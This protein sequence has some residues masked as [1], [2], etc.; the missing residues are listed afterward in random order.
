LQRHNP[1]RHQAVSALRCFLFIAFAY[2]W[3][4]GLSFPAILKFASAGC[5]LHQLPVKK[6]MLHDVYL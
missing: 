2:N 6:S 3:G 1:A 4:D 5:M